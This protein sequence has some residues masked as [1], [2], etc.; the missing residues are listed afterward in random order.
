MNFLLATGSSVHQTATLIMLAKL[1]DI[2]VSQPT[3]DS[4]D[5]ITEQMAQMVA[6]VKTTVWGG[7]HGSLAL[8]L[9]NADNATVTKNIVTLSAP[10]N[11]PTTINPRINKL[12]NLYEILTLQEEMKLSR[13]SSNSKRQSLP[14]EF[15]AS[16]TAL[17]NSL[18]KNSTKATLVTSIKPSKCS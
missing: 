14:M 4:M 18:S 2:I 17:K 8:V 11:K 3:T 1:L 15:S 10:L 12:S 9:D 5:R 16:L 6:P 7:L 13:K